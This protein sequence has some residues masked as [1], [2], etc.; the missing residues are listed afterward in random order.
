MEELLKIEANFEIARVNSEPV[1]ST[2]FRTVN[3]QVD[4]VP[5]ITEDVMVPEVTPLNKICKKN[6]Q[7]VRKCLNSETTDKIKLLQF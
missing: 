3:Q 6:K 7:M 2:V 4:T 1:A 5:E